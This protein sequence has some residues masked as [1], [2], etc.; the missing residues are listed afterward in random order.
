MENNLATKQIPFASLEAD[1]LYA[2]VKFELW[3]AANHQPHKL[4]LFLDKAFELLAK[5]GFQFVFWEVK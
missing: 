2:R 5:E 3:K 1:M 4:H